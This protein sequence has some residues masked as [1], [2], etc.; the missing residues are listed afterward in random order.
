MTDGVEREIAEVLRDM[1]E[2]TTHAADCDTRENGPK[3]FGR[4][5]A[6]PCSCTRPERVRQRQAKAFATVID[7]LTNALPSG[8]ATSRQAALSALRRSAG[9]RERDQ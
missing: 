1:E 6:F 4:W 8:G 2:R 7:M 9:E 5:Q 3:E